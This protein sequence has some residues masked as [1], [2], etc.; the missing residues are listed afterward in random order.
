MIRNMAA[1]SLTEEGHQIVLQTPGLHHRLRGAILGCLVPVLLG[2]SVCLVAVLEILQVSDPGMITAGVAVFASLVAMVS[3]PWG[4]VTA[5]RAPALARQTRVVIDLERRVIEPSGNAPEVPLS[6]V[7]GVSLRKPQALLQWMTIEA[8]LVS[9]LPGDDPSPYRAPRSR[10]VV[11]LQRISGLEA[12]SA[13]EMMVQLG[14]RLDLPVCSQSEPPWV[15]SGQGNGRGKISHVAAYVP[16]QGLFFIV[17]LFLLIGR[18]GEPRAMFHARQSLLLLVLEFVWVVGVALVSIPLMLLSE[19]FGG[20]GPHPAGVVFLTAG[21][22]VF[23]VVRLGIRFY[24]AW[25]TWKGDTW[26]VPFVALISKRW[27][28]AEDDL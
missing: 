28:P 6:S 9:V 8:D 16:V 11:L 23:L 22:V 18:R 24:A 20:N 5:L 4:L 27:L 19:V 17:S 3:V 7:V 15:G 25:R 10:S 13:H 14:Q 26:L 1:H 21:L 12:D 2:V